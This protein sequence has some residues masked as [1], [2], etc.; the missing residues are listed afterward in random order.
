M[1]VFL[2]N[3]RRVL[4]CQGTLPCLSAW[5]ERF[6]KTKELLRW[7]PASQ[8]LM[9]YYDSSVDCKL[10]AEIRTDEDKQGK[11]RDSSGEVGGV[12]VE[13]ARLHIANYQQAICISSRRFSSLLTRHKKAPNGFRHPCGASSS[14]SCTCT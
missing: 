14:S 10:N 2:E 4:S 3:T 1:P 8:T 12:L 7:F 9:K 6:R 11:I 5:I 13:V